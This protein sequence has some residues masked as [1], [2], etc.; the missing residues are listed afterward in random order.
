LRRR[1]NSRETKDSWEKKGHNCIFC[2]NHAADVILEVYAIAGEKKGYVSRLKEGEKKPRK[3]K[4][5]RK[6]MPYD[7]I[8]ANPKGGWKA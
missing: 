6:A 8:S 1:V 2:Q 5:F 3:K 7:K 4:E